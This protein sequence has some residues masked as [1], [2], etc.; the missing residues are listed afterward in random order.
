LNQGKSVNSVSPVH[1]RSIGDII[2][3]LRK[4]SADQVAQ[5]LHH[6]QAKGLRFGEAAVALG[7]ASADDVNYA[8]SQ[9]FHYPYAPH[10][11]NKLSDELVV[12]GQSFGEQAERF[13]AVRSQVI[14]RYFG[15]AGAP[16]RALAVVSADPGDG[17][18][19]VAANLAVALAQVGGKTLLID[20]NL[21]QPRQHEL[22]KLEGGTGLSNILAG[23]AESG[24]VRPIAAVPGLCVLP[25]GVTPPNPV[26]LVERPAFGLLLQELVAKFDHVVVDTPAATSGS[27]AS[28]VAARCGGALLVA[29]K[30]ESRIGDLQA[31]AASL[32][33]SS[34]RLVGALVNA[35]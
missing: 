6:Q 35:F 24:A 15:E 22:F 26:E 33:Q 4:L 32:Q 27:D 3:D 23:R 31:I 7:L 20:A 1:D 8:L 11:L 16:R 9:Q 17:K 5:I 14:M 21:R 12:L 2:A 25:V 29:R 30:H 28:V 18:T 34:T 19:F 10:E 13:R